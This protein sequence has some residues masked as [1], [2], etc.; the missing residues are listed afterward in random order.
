MKE[1]HCTQL[2]YNSLQAVVKVPYWQR[3]NNVSHLKTS[4][5]LAKILI[6]TVTKKNTFWKM[7]QTGGFYDSI[8]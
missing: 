8:K 2:H 5:H 7:G 3:C 1:N 6:K 4:K